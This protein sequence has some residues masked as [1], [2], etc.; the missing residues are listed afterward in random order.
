MTP[1]LEKSGNLL[2]LRSENFPPVGHPD[3]TANLVCCKMT[4]ELI[5]RPAELLQ[6][7][8]LRIN[9]QEPGLIFIMVPDA[10]RIWRLG[11]FE[12]IYHEHCCY[13][14]AT[15][16][17]ACCAASGFRVLECRPVYDG[18]YLWLMA[19]ATTLP[20]PAKQV[21]VTG[22]ECEAFDGFPERFCQRLA[23]V[24]QFLAA[25][26]RV[27]VWG[28]SSKAVALLTHTRHPGRIAGVVDINP[29]K[30]GGY[31]PPHGHVVI[32]PR[33]LASQVLD[34]VIIMNEKYQPEIASQLQELN[35]VTQIYVM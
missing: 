8:R 5:L 31:L 34:G 20:L 26:E 14:T 3:L 35:C 33:M 17:A 10:S 32:S 16:L 27:F 1:V 7:V 13:F 9:W 6:Q 2:Q 15:S 4:L 11:A 18:Q 24:E 21:P 22:L 29:R 12:D 28:G 19:E 30:Q 23:M 25:R